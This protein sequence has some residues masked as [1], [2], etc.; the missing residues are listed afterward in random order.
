VVVGAVF[1]V[2][3]I[4]KL[5][6]PDWSRTAGAFGLP[7]LLG[8]VLPWLEIVLGALLVAQVGGRW[9]SISAAAVLV[10][11]TAAVAYR[12]LR[13]DPVPCACFGGL[14]DRPVSA[15]T[16]VRNVLLLAV[17]AVGSLPSP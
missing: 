13:R 15:T 3:G 17:A 1:L 14:S 9:T 6:L 16:I 8:P 4:A 10:A 5:R 2:A 7:A 11:F 12:L